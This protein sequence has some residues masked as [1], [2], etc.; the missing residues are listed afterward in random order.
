MNHEEFAARI[1][2]GRAQWE[3]EPYSKP[4][5][6]PSL[7]IPPGVD[8]LEWLSAEEYAA[9]RP[10]GWLVRETK[11]GPFTE[12]GHHPSGV[13]DLYVRNADDFLKLPHSGSAGYL[14]LFRCSVCGKT[15]RQP[16]G[17][18]FPDEECRGVEGTHE[19]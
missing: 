3:S 1:A 7:E 15:W 17:A 2:A 12:G 10:L 18:T 13:G 4:L 8:L 16:E 19:P 5:R 11:Y 14:C 6:G 9:L